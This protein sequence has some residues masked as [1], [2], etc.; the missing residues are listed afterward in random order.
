MRT[1][2]KHRRGSAL[3]AS[4]IA[5]GMLAA[6]SAALANEPGADVGT[7]SALCG[8]QYVDDDRIHY[9]HYTGMHAIPSGTQ[10]T[11]AGIEAQC[12]LARFSRVI[13]DSDMDPGGIDGIFGSNSQQAM[14]AFQRW[15][16][17]WWD[18]GLDVD[19][20]PGPESW[21]HLRAHFI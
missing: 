13:P 11:S 17:R 3:L 21:P 9:G 14:K 18:A 16:N 2:P 15:A 20:W 8:D 1:I 10:V 5:L 7:A 4:T 6:P 19:G 12:L